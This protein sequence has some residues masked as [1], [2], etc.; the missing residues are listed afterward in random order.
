MKTKKSKDYIRLL[1]IHLTF[2]DHVLFILFCINSNTGT[3]TNEIQLSQEEQTILHLR[4]D[5]IETSY[6]CC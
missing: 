1:K 3:N 6:L 5:V 2:N 4:M